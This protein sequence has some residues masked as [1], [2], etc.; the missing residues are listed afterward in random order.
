MGE[1]A[2]LHGRRS[3]CAAVDQRIRVRL[4]PR[5]DRRFSIHSALGDLEGTLED[6]TPREP[7]RFVL[8]ALGRAGLRQGLDLAIEADFSSTLGFGSSAAVTVATV[9]ALRAAQGEP[10]DRGGIFRQSRD[11][12]RAVQGR[13]SG[14]DAAAATYGGVVLYRADPVEIEA[15]RATPPIS[16]LYAGYKTATPAVIARVEAARQHAPALFEGIF[17]LMDQACAEA[18]EAL[19]AGDLPRLGRLWNLHHGLQEALGTGDETLARLV[20]GLRGQPGVLGAKISGSGLGDCVIALG[21]ADAK[22]PPYE[23]IPATLSPEG[24]LLET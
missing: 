8:A 2:V 9:A 13:G 24:V 6:L 12:I 11:I 3:L 21:T 14:A 23:A 16:V 22:L 10:M 17:D 20:H 5:P 4:T 19:R 1:H 7:F 15:L 18:V